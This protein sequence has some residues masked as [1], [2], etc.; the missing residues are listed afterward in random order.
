MKRDTCRP[1]ALLATGVV[2]A[3]AGDAWAQTG[4]IDDATFEVDAVTG[5]QNLSSLTVTREGVTEIFTLEDLIGITIDDIATAFPPQGGPA[6]FGVPGSMPP[7]AEPPPGTRNDLLEDFAINT[8]INNPGNVDGFVFSFDEPI[9]NGPG[10]DLVLF[11]LS[12]PPGEPPIGGQVVPSLAVGGDP[13]TIQGT[14]D[15]SNFV[16][17]FG[18]DLFG[19]LPDVAVED[20]A[21]FGSGDLASAS[22]NVSGLTEFEEIAV[23][24]LITGPPF[25]LQAIGI[26]LSNLGIEAGA[27]VGQLEL[28]SNPLVVLNSSGGL[29]GPF[30]VDPAL[31]VGLPPLSVPEPGV[32][33]L[34]A[35]AGTALASRRRSSGAR[36]GSVHRRSR[37]ASSEGV[38]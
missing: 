24:L 7:T 18:P 37:R 12:P 4:P 1:V 15:L 22:A 17:G 32:L 19:A 31:I 11:E 33:A 20:I 26:D 25:L 5:L 9:V 29:S 28:L 16:A 10:A 30:G 3:L 34:L 2:V 21:F 35:V 8:V 38:A 36:P 27:S 14:G 23:S 13:F 6:L